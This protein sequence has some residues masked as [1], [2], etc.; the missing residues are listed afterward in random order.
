M[1][2]FRPRNVSKIQVFLYSTYILLKRLPTV[3]FLVIIYMIKY[4]T[5]RIQHNKLI[6]IEID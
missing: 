1:N 5:N 2:L 6:F 4:V 3:I